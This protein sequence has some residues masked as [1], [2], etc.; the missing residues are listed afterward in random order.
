MRSA[1]AKK[2]YN[3]STRGFL[4]GIAC[5][6]EPEYER[7]RFDGGSWGSSRPGLNV[8]QSTQMTGLRH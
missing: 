4:H 8:R 7:V 6:T 3:L 5:G 1:D 2:A